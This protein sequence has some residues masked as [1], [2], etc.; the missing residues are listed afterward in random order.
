MVDAHTG[1]GDVSNVADTVSRLE[2][3]GAS[4]I[5]LE[6]RTWPKRCGHL[7]G[8]TVETAEVM[9]RKLAAALAASSSDDFFVIA[10]TDA[11]S[12]LGLDEA[13]L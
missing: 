11:R 5:Q 12:P 6:D 8:K 9:E 1:Y 13:I 2:L 10:R 7:S 4:G 3:A